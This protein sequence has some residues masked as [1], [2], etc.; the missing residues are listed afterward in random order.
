MSVGSHVSPDAAGPFLVWWFSAP[1]SRGPL[2]LTFLAPFLLGPYCSWHSAK[3]GCLPFWAFGYTEPNA[4]WLGKARRLLGGCCR[5]VAVVL[6]VPMAVDLA[7]CIP[8]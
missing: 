4:V 7:L 8:F 6:V 1:I 3:D 5:C 2:N